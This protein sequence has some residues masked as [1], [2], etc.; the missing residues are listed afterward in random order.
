M[1]YGDRVDATNERMN[2]LGIL[3]RDAANR[4]RPWSETA[5]DKKPDR[6]ITMRFAALT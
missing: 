2:L 4:I 3:K 6:C 1:V 5:M